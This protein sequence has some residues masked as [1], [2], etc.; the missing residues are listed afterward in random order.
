M[1]TNTKN[2]LKKSISCEGKKDV[3]EK[4]GCRQMGK[5]ERQWPFFQVFLHRV[6]QHLVT[7]R[8]ISKPKGYYASISIQR[9]PE[10]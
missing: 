1:T 5:E 2:D 3:R 4:Q 8:L 6:F 7:F 9:A 10:V